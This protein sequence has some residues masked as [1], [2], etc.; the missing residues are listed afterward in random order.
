[1]KNRIVGLNGQPISSKP[2][3]E[4]KASRLPNVSEMVASARAKWRSGDKQ[5]AFDDL[6]E[7]ILLLSAGTGRLFQDMK[8]IKERMT[9]K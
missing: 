1:M 6:C 9:P 8:E 5:Q 3:P 4:S 2:P 7:T